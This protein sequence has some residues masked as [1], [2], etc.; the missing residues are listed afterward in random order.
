MSNRTI[1]AIPALFCACLPFLGCAPAALPDLQ[2]ETEGFVLPGAK[3]RIPGM[4]TVYVA[5]PSRYA[6]RVSFNV[7][8]E[9]TR[10]DTLEAGSNKAGQHI[11]FS[12]NPGR[13][14]LFSVA[15]NTAMVELDFQ[16]D[17]TYFFRQDVTAGFIMARNHLSETDS[18]EGKYNVKITEP[19]TMLRT[20]L[21]A[22]EKM[23]NGG[24]S[25]R[26]QGLHVLADFRI[27]SVTGGLQKRSGLVNDDGDKANVEKIGFTIALRYF[28]FDRMGIHVGTGG[29]WGRATASG[30][31]PMGYTNA[32]ST[33][34]GFVAVPWQMEAGKGVLQLGVA[35]GLD[36]TRLA[37]A[38]EYKDFVES[39]QDFRFNDDAGSG[40]GWYAGPELQWLMGNGF[41][42]RCDARFMQENPRF[43]KGSRDFDGSEIL[44]GFGLGFRF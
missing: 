2:K 23:R 22:T 34:L 29:L 6:S 13:H 41:L 20:K 17:S 12:L 14:R 37:F 15:E 18:L 11:W 3:A 4:A 5:R 36:Y 39:Q 32:W 44:I 1:F 25:T 7:F 26:S 9:N 31:E 27:G 42:A 33:D 28:F 38:E 21:V 24:R 43:P 10:I 8:A 16:A 40:I 35:A 19:G 30:T